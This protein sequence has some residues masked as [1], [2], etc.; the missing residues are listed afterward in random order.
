MRWNRR[1]TLRS[2][3]V[4]LVRRARRRGRS[5][6]DVFLQVEHLSKA[7]QYWCRET[8]RGRRGR[9]DRR[10]AS[11]VLLDQLLHDVPRIVELFKPIPE[12]VLLLVLL[13]VR[14]SLTEQ[15]VL[16]QDPLEVLL[17]RTPRSANGQPFRSPRK[18]NEVRQKTKRTHGR[19]RG[20]VGE[21]QTADSVTLLEVRA[22]SRQRHLD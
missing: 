22:T 9:T 17:A 18:R 6:I 10:L 4:S 12:H 5:V 11:L 3:G 13:N 15:V 2:R 7:R 8:N 21:H 16:L 1:G 19:N 20:V 14:S